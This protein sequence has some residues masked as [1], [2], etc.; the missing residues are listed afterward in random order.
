[1]IRAA[2]MFYYKIEIYLLR[3]PSTRIVRSKQW[4]LLYSAHP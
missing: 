4:A 2:F 3:L 1:M